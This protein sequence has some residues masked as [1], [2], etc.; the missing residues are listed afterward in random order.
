[1]QACKYVR[2]QVCKY[3]GMQ[4]CKYASMQVCKNA[5]KVFKYLKYASILV[6][7]VCK[8]YASMQ[9]LCKYASMHVCKY[10]C[11]QICTGAHG[12]IWRARLKRE[13]SAAPLDVKTA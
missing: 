4:V 3:A 2:V 5:S 10:A 6:Y 13:Q 12:M 9:V 11:M 8:Y 7:Q 1:M